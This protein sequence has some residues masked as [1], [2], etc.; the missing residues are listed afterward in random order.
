M[1]AFLDLKCF[2]VVVCKFTGQIYRNWLAG[3]FPSLKSD[4]AATMLQLYPAVRI[5]LCDYGVI[6]V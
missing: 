3:N 2:E 4:W 5:S 6:S 1:C